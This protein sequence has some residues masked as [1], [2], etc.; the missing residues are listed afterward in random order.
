MAIAHPDDVDRLS[1]GLL[2]AARWKRPLPSCFEHE[3][4]MP[5]KSAHA[6]RPGRPGPPDDVGSPPPAY[7]M[8]TST[9]RALRMTTKVRKTASR[10]SG[11]RSDLRGA[12]HIASE[13]TRPWPALRIHIGRPN[14]PKSQPSVV[15]ASARVGPAPYH[16]ISVQE[17][18]PVRPLPL[19]I[20]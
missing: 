2:R 20:S 5:G 14:H 18:A 11:G 9:A 8:G 19:W 17:H 7:K 10:P 12:L 16:D 3:C 13:P 1:I 6:R 4:A 15:F